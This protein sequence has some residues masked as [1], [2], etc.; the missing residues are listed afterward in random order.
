MSSDPLADHGPIYI[1]QLRCIRTG[2]VALDSLLTHP[3]EASRSP[4]L[5]LEKNNLDWRK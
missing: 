4:R 2:H 5:D 1:D 3:T